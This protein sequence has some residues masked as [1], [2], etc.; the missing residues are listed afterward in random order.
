MLEVSST[1]WRNV[2]RMLRPGCIAAR[3]ARARCR[4][5]MINSRSSS[6]ATEA[7]VE[8]REHHAASAAMARVV[9]GQRRRGITRSAAASN[10]APG[11]GGH[12]GTAY[13]S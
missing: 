7:V 10:R 2:S 3:A 8:R 1:A 9:P 5:M 6:C 13:P 4:S 12:A 11:V